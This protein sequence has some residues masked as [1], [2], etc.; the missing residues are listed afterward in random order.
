MVAPQMLRTADRRVMAAAVTLPLYDR[1]VTITAF[2]IVLPIPKDEVSVVDSWDRAGNIRLSR[3]GSPDIE[4]VKFVTAYGGQTE[5]EVDLT[6]LAPLLKGNCTF[7]AFIDT[8]LTPAWEIDFELVYE[9]VGDKS[10]PDWA[11]GLVYVESYTGKDYGNNGTE[12]T[13]TVPDDMKRVKL[14]YYASGHCTDGTDADEFVT[15]DNVIYVDGIAVYRYRPWRDDC[16]QFRDINPYTRRWSDGY[17]SS[18]YSRSGWCPGDLVE[19]LVLDLTDHLTP[20]E[21]KIRFVVEDV[22]ALDDNGHFGYWRIS[23]YLTGWTEK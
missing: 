1:P 14:N 20:G 23:S 17:W 19:P 9:P 3:E 16:R 5:Y 10:A 2:L 13:V 15:K 8:W 6:P 22:R 11:E 7:K 4:L 21:H 12:V 18:D